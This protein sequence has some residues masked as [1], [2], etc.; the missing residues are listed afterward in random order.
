MN[1]RNNN[2][3]LEH[4]MQSGET[5]QKEDHGEESSVYQIV[6]LK[7]RSEPNRETAS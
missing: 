5:T 6:Q 4:T 2:R 3:G 1:A 7:G